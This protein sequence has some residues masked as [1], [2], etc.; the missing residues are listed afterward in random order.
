MK[1]LM[2]TSAL[3]LVTALAGCAGREAHPVAVVQ[4]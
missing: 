3:A 4:P 1:K 2:L